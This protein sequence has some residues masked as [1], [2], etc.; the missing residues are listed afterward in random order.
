MNIRSKLLLG[1]AAIALIPLA[2]TSLLVGQTTYSTARDSLN[3]N[4]EER[5]VATRENKKAQ[6]EDYLNTLL[7]QVQA[8]GSSSTAIDALKGF[9]QSPAGIVK[10]TG[11]DAKLASY[12][13]ALA[14]YYTKDFAGEY[15]KRNASK[16]PD[17]AA[18]VEKLD[19]PALA[20]Q[21]HYIA[22]NQNPLGQK[23]KLFA[24]TDGSTYSKAHTQFHPSFESF[25]KRLGLYDVFL[26]DPDT[27]RIVYTVFKELDFGS[28]LETG[29]AAKTKLAEVVQKALAAKSKDDVFISDYA[30]YLASY[31]D[32]AAFIAAP[33]FDGDK[34]AGVIAVQV[35]IDKINNIMTSGKKWTDV[36][37]G[38]TGETY[39]VGQDNLVRSEIRFLVEDKNK[40]LTNNADQFG[41]ERVDIMN[42]RNTAVG[43]LPVKTD[44]VTKALAG[45]TGTVTYRG[46][47][48]FDLVGAYTPLKIQGLTWALVAK[49]DASEVFAAADE[50]RKNT[51]LVALIAGLALAALATLGVYFFVRRF[52]QPIAKLQSTVE[53]VASGDFSARSQIRTG[54]EMQALGGAFDNLLDDR[55]AALA[56]AEDEN[57]KLNNSVIGLLTTVADLSQKDLTARAPVTED[58]IGTVGDSINQL[59]DA[60]TSVLRDVTKIAGV[61]EHASKRVKQQ[62][63][64]VNVQAGEE[65]LTVDK[66]VLSLKTA[67]DGMNRVAQLAENSN[68]AASEASAS[69]ANAMTTV[70]TTVRGM[71]AI[72]ETIG[73]MEKR[74]KRLGERSQEISQIVSLINTISERTHVLSLNA[75]MQ[76]AMAGEAGRG[77]A[78]V[79]EEVQRLAENSRQ[80]T[81][82]IAN[83]VQNIQIE[84]NDTIAT[85]N[86]TI[87]QVVQ[88]SESARNSGERMRE[89]R[90]TTERLVQLVQTIAQSSQQ[91]LVIAEDL[92]LAAGEITAST[93]KTAD[94]LSAQNQVTSSLLTA[95]QK[96]V[97][98]VS[99]FKLPP[100]TQS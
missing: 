88:G 96:L 44:A 48:G 100:V 99:V 47:R 53:K 86:R 27:K 65:R 18:V 11:G 71:D 25:Q 38:K 73:E 10:D 72:R 70:Q 54:D 2:L 60:T 33:I 90:D 29:I 41:K 69:T 19:A 64:A 31:D 89:T 28:S 43:V 37:L 57:E 67:T 32:P 97:E 4:A 23:D 12:K 92:R 51:L 49:Q 59:T 14:S 85:V 46:Y 7:S 24:S 6:I 5:L 39:L 42:K 84:T 50:L 15:D 82:Q 77:F 13:T 8:I 91:Q 62:S 40:W 63:D 3:S 75:S 94:Q 26:V 80:A 16:A 45:E 58:V 76:A 61:V 30:S 22:A 98:S 74:I 21:Y 55:I 68:K 9:K 1:G 83:L 52:M 17:M 36:G 34:I 20:M 79:A 56:K 93:E 95:S 78:V 87:D 81:A 35:P 66:L